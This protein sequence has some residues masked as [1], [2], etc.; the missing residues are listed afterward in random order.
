MK[1]TNEQILEIRNFV[2]SH[3][4]RYYDVQL[5][6]IDHMA[7]NVEQLMTAHPGLTLNEAIAQTH[8]EFGEAGFKVIQEAMRK[9]LQKRYWKLFRAVFTSYLKPVYL[10]LEVGLVYLICMFAKKTDTVD[11][12]VDIT[13]IVVFLLSG[14]LSFNNLRLKKYKRMLAMQMGVI[15]TSVV[16]VP[17]QLFIWFFLLGPIPA[18]FGTVATAVICGVFLIVLIITFFT[19]RQIKKVALNNCQEL[20]NQYKITTGS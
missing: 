12:P 8:V 17:I 5:E 13:W 18:V 16:N 7:C 11:V 14:I 6:I 10:L 20:E 15:V 9:S 1:L 3:G 2:G 4:I 19:L